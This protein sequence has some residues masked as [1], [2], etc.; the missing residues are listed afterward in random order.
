MRHHRG[1]PVERV[2]SG[3]EGGLRRR[4]LLSQPSR[5]TVGGYRGG[6]AVAPPDFNQLNGL[7][8]WIHF[9]RSFSFGLS[10]VPGWM[11]LTGHF[12]AACTISLKL[13]ARGS[14]MYAC[15]LAS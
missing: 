4:K 14:L 11:I 12:S 15:F 7:A 6:A 8:R 1:C 2:G 10:G 9:S 3:F 5:A 13:P